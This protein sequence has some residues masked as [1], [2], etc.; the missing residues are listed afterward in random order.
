[1]QTSKKSIRICF[2]WLNI[3]SC[4]RSINILF[5]WITPKTGHLCYQPGKSLLTLGTWLN[6]GCILIWELET[7][8]NSFWFHVFILRFEHNNGRTYRHI[9]SS[10]FMKI[11][12]AVNW[13]FSARAWL[14]SRSCPQQPWVLPP[15][16][17]WL[18]P[19]WFKPAGRNRLKPLNFDHQKRLKLA[20]IK[21]KA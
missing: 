11:D 18:K 5:A 17:M 7:S 4:L 13:L 3:E 12:F 19:D 6:W 10:D 20:K 15:G 14:R 1:M 8:V 9:V 21:K 2:L 16:L